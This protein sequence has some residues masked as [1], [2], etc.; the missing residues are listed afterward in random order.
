M[1]IKKKIVGIDE[2]HENPEIIIIHVMISRE[3]C[4]RREKVRTKI[5][6]MPHGQVEA[7][8]VE[9]VE[10]YW[11]YIVSDDLSTT[12]ILAMQKYVFL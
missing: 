3:L 1:K 5:F 10:H 8:F 7:R 6:D 12:A 4:Q 9:N 11:D 2:D